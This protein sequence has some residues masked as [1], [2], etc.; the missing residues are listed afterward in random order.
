M[1]DSRSASCERLCSEL[2]KVANDSFKDFP[3]E[4]FVLIGNLKYKNRQQL[5]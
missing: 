5:E 3:I 1:N 2:K 4:T